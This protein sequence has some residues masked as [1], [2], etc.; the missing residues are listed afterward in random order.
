MEK[1]LFYF[2]DHKWN[3]PIGVPLAG[4]APVGQAA[5]Y[6][7]IWGIIITTTKQQSRGYHANHVTV[8][9]GM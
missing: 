1:S 9:L 8:D 6:Y 4:K 2:L 7:R 5:H 3:R